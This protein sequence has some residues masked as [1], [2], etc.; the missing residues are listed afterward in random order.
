MNFRVGAANEKIKIIV[1]PRG[2]NLNANDFEQ[3]NLS[4]EEVIKIA[5]DTGNN[6]L[7][8]VP[9]VERVGSN[10]IAFDVVFTK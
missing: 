5:N 8:F 2:E 6:D 4:R 7:L 9:L 10:I 1:L 3:F